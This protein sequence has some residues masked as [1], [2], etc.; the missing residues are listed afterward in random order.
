[1]ARRYYKT[2]DGQ[3]IIANTL[4]DVTNVSFREYILK[5]HSYSIAPFLWNMASRLFRSPSIELIVRIVSRQSFQLAKQELDDLKTVEFP[6]GIIKLL[7]TDLRK[8]EQESILNGLSL[9]TKQLGAIFLYGEELGFGFSSYRF[10]GTPKNYK[11]EDLPDFAY[12]DDNDNLHKV[13]G[14]SL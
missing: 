9:T 5:F 3:T 10:E 4:D 7:N 8:K 13:G 12:I 6:Q 14:E 2:K 1:M 11:K